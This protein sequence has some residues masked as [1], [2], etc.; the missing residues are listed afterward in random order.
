MNKTT[1]IQFCHVWSALGIKRTARMI[2]VWTLAGLICG[3]LPVSVFGHGD[4]HEAIAAVSK[5]IEAAPQNAELYL[6]RG[7]L[8]RTDQDWVAALADFD[9]AAA[10]DPELKIVDLA[11]GEVLADQGRF[12]EAEAAITRYVESRADDSRP[13]SVRGRIR[14]GQ[15]R[16]QEAAEDF[17]QAVRLATQSD[18]QL[19]LDHVRALRES[20][21]NAEALKALDA[22]IG[23]LG[24]LVVL[25]QP[26]VELEEHAGNIDAALS[27]I[28]KAIKSAPRKERWLA[29]KGEL[30]ERTG[31][32]ADARA[33]F[34][35]ALRNFEELPNERRRVAAMVAF[36]EKVRTAIARLGADAQAAAK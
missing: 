15:G 1:H 36:E 10:I 16:W 2:R 23:K 13:W 31:R 27:R 24:P 33:A 12:K 11:R 22:A 18:P 20:G 34:E 8:Y 19:I 7:S 14:A 4:V 6:R 17:G 32:K 5:E 21:Q 25:V 29:Q 28:D 35:E 30:L 3:M 26:A 9:R